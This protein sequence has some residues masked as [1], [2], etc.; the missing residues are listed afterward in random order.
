MVII[1]EAIEQGM[2]DSLHQQIRVWF[3]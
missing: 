3:Y 2:Q 1:L